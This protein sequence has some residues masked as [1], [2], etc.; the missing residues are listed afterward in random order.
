M[1]EGKLQEVFCC[2]TGDKTWVLDYQGQRE[3]GRSTISLPAFPGQIGLWVPREC[4][5]EMGTGSNQGRIGKE[6]CD[7]HLTRM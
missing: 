2:R 1:Q 3:S 6:E 5:L 7:F 4:L